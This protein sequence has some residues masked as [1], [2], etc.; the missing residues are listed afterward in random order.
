MSDYSDNTA[1]GMQVSRGVVVAS[2]QADLEEQVVAR[3]R[4]D[5]L[6][7]VHS[8]GSKGAILDLSAVHT[9]DASEFAAIR[10]L[11]AMIEIM[12]ATPVLAGLRSG[13][14]SALIDSGV[15]VN[16]IQAAVD[17]D[18]AFELLFEP[19]PA[20]AETDEADPAAEGDTDSAGALPPAGDEL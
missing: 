19:E 14:V 16:G 2:V 18:A 12:G 8:T 1:S 3:L 7:R 9:L 20:G 6:A 15:D 11:I 13:V 4:D 17:L 10:E 5:L